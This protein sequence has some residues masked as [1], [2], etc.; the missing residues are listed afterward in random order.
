MT[1]YTKFTFSEKADSNVMQ[2][3]RMAMQALA[4]EMF[5]LPSTPDKVG[6][7]VSLPPPKT[8]LP[9]EKPVCVS[10]LTLC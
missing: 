10:L 1:F 7:I 3:G 6:R 8:A 4:K 5:H 2:L 9:R